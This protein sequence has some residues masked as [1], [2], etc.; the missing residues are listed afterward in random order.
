MKLESIP[1]VA[2]GYRVTHDHFV[3]SRKAKPRLSNPDQN[4]PGTLELLTIVT[5]DRTLSG[6]FS[7]FAAEIA[8]LYVDMSTPRRFALGHADCA[9]YIDSPVPHPCG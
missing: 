5:L 3:R 7:S 2:E 9:M 4:M 6:F 8:S 1:T